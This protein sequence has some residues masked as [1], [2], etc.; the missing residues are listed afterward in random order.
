[1]SVGI[2]YLR[3]AWESLEADLEESSLLSFLEAGLSAL[4]EYNRDDFDKIINKLRELYDSNEDLRLDLN[5]SCLSN[6]VYTPRRLLLRV[7]FRRNNRI[8][9]YKGVSYEEVANLLL[10]GSR[11]VVFN[12]DIKTNHPYVEV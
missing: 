7:T 9:V 6:I 8:Y 4:K 3:E 12:R 2:E 11:G 1:M 10:S 5:S